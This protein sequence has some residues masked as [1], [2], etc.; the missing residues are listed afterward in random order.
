MQRLKEIVEKFLSDPSVVVSAVYRVDGTPIVAGIKDR[1]YLR[2]LQFFEDQTKA[3]FRLILDGSL[4]SVELKTKDYT[5]IFYPLSR[6]LVLLVVST[7]EASIYK[8]KIDV[9][10]IRAFLNV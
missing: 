9:E 5:A 10:S 3:V 1:N 2:F 6:T 7:S 4:K 8:L